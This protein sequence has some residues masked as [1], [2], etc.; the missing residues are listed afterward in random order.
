MSKAASSLRQVAK[1]WLGAAGKTGFAG[2]AIGLAS[3]MRGFV[4]GGM[5]SPPWRQASPTFAQLKGR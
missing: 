4:G 3:G 1:A 5:R 2:G